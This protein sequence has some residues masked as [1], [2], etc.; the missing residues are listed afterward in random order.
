MLILIPGLSL[1]ERFT[2]EGITAS[3][4][5][6]PF[7]KKIKHP[8]NKARGNALPMLVIEQMRSERRGDQQQQQQKNHFHTSPTDP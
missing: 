8:D 2:T 6:P 4:M 1:L 7:T 5:H 3:D